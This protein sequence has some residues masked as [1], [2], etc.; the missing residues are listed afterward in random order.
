MRRLL[1]AMALLPLL[2]PAQA[3]VALVETLNVGPGTG[4]PPVTLAPLNGNTAVGASGTSA[5]TSGAVALPLAGATSWLKVV[6]GAT[7]HDVHI[8]VTARSGFGLVTDT[9]TV[10]VGGATVTV[11]PLTVL[12]AST[13]AVNL[14]T[15]SDLPVTAA[16]LCAGTCTLTMEIRIDADGAGANPVLAYPVT[17]TV[18]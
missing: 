2:L 10:A 15:A 5:T 6:H 8:A 13:A 4:A 16:G 12:P 7:A 1:A 9:V 17:L 18:T 14:G 3:S 11:T